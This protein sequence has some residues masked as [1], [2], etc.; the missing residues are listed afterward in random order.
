[1][2]DLCPTLPLPSPDLPRVALPGFAPTA[3]SGELV[4][5]AIRLNQQLP[6]DP[7][8][9]PASPRVTLPESEILSFVE[10]SK[11][12]TGSA[13]R[14]ATQAELPPSQATPAKKQCQ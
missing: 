11:G 3:N 13:K 10:V 8:S 4:K 1:M 6:K 14:T 12:D 5:D 2:G 9:S 7:S